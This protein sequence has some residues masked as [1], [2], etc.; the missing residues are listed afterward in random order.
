MLQ[1]ILIG[2]ALS[3]ER[4]EPRVLASVPGDQVRF[5]REAWRSTAGVAAFWR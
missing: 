2:V 5:H 4:P 1:L 3:Y